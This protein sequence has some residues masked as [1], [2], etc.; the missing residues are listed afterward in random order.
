MSATSA[1]SWT[2][3]RQ[4]VEKGIDSIP[5][6]L[7]FVCDFCMAA[8]LTALAALLTIAVLYLAERNYW[9]WCSIVGDSYAPTVL[10]AMVLLTFCT[11]SFVKGR[12]ESFVHSRGRAVVESESSSNDFDNND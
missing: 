10:V 11:L 3:F 1:T 6:L 12:F 5:V 9:Y 4:R 7:L 8:P 2:L